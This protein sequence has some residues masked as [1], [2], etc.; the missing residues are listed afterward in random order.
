MPVSGPIVPT[1]VYLADLYGDTL[2]VKP[3]G[4]AAGFSSQA[5]TS[6][7]AQI[8]QWLKEPAVKHLAVDMSGTNYVGSVILGMLVRWSQAI[9]S[10]GGRAALCGASPDMQDVLRLMKLDAMW[11][12]FPTRAA[13]LRA[14]ATIPFRERMWRQR[15]SFLI[16][17]GLAAVVTLYIVY[18]RP[19]YARINY[20]KLIALWQEAERRRDLA[21]EE[22]WSNLQKRMER[23]IAPILADMNRR[24]PKGQVSI[25][26]R[27]LLYNVRDSWRFAMDRHNANVEAHRRQVRKNFRAAEAFLEGR[28]IP[29]VT[30][31]DAPSAKSADEDAPPSR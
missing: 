21:G 22:E 8:D 13:G 14:V 24:G 28:P 26:E 9:R 31:E 25:A 3:R 23:E 16:L 10:R 12:Q 4:D 11:E 2:V 17:I 7:T 27:Y 30:P 19:N 29:Q 20:E 15:R 18:P 1:H 5:V 6:E